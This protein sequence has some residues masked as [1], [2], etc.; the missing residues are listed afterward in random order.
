MRASL[1]VCTLGVVVCRQRAHIS[2]SP[3]TLQ[4][5]PVQTPHMID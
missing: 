5:V 1:L 3:V 2:T 4:G